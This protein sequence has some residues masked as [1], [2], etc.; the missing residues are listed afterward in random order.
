MRLGLAVALGVLCSMCSFACTRSATGYY[1]TTEPKHGPTEAWVNLAAEPEYID[2]NK[3]SDHAGNTIIG[4]IFSGLLQPHPVTLEPLPEIAERWDVSPDGM[5][6]TFHLRP[7]VWSDGTPLTAADFVYSWRRMLDPATMSKYGSFLYG[8]RYGEMFNRRAL[9][10]R[11]VGNASEA[12]VRKLVEPIV[13]LEAVRLAPELGAAFLLVAGAD[14]ER[15]ALRDRALREMSKKTMN[16][17]ALTIEPVSA[18]LVGIQALD[19]LTFQVDLETPLPYFLHIAKFYS[20]SPVPRHVIERLIR[21]GK[22]PELWTRPE[23]IVSNGPFVLAEAKFRQSMVLARN[24]RYWDAA[25]VKL[26]R[27]RISLIESNNTTLNM[28]EAGEI[29]SI[30][31]NATLPAEFLDVLKQQKDFVSQPYNATYFYW[32]NTKAPPLDDARVR[33]ALRF[34]VDR[35]TLVERI[36]RAG[37]LPSSDIVPDNLAGYEGLHSPIFDPDRA[38]QLLREA[39]YGPD[40]PLPAIVLRYNTSESHK[41][42]AEALQ[43][44]WRKHLGVTVELENQEWKVFLKSLNAHDFQIAR[45]GWIG[46][47][48]DPYTFLELLSSHNGNNH[49]GWGSPEYDAMLDRANRALDPAQRL[50]VLREAEAIAMAAAPL[51][52]MYTYTRSELIKPYLRGH[53]INYESRFIFK[54]WWIDERWYKG[55]PSELAPHGFPPQ[56]SAAAGAGGAGGA[57]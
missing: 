17:A 13:P 48:P 23:Y 28:Y 44:M 3:A 24:P 30:G 19:D 20:T 16:G 56:P 1:G 32:I 37:Q 39:G 43:A 42:V 53:V 7:S 5:R 26:A 34:A 18:E 15:Q 12:E 9:L 4:N 6:Y 38:R 51:M 29:D 41:Q 14:G 33:N 31:P 2:P 22:N 10:M 21:E 40:R 55:T 57:H 36:T 47:Y 45:M 54:Y 8:V 25:H 46:D 11:G 52:P 27:I 49:S 35:K 50:K